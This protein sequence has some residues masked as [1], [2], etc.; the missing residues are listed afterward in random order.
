[1]HLIDVMFIK[2]FGLPT[3][4]DVNTYKEGKQGVSNCLCGEYNHAACIL[5][6]KYRALKTS[7]LCYGCNTPQTHA[8]RDAINKLKPLPSSKK[9]LQNI[10]LLV[11]RLS[12]KSKIQNSKPC[13]NCISYM[14]LIPQKK[15]YKI[16]HIYYSNHDGHIIKSN[17]KRLEM[18]ELH[19]SKYYRNKYNMKK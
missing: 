1:M 7:I 5:R 11:V 4:I 10:N 9:H 8:E 19:Y 2:R 14:K 6:G 13:A 17:L 18:E 12:S 15:G 16:K 3:D